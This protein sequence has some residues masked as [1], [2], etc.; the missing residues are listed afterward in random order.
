MRSSCVRWACQYG[1]DHRTWAGL[2]SVDEGRWDGNKKVTISQLLLTYSLVHCQLVATQVVLQKKTEDH[3]VSLHSCPFLD[4]I[5]WEEVFGEDRHIPFHS[6][7]PTMNVWWWRNVSFVLG[8]F[9]LS[10]SLSSR[11]GETNLN[12]PLGLCEHSTL[13]CGT[14]QSRSADLSSL[15]LHD[16]FCSRTPSRPHLG[17]N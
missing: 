1:H 6:S 13:E 7:L 15:S 10:F 17:I 9:F 3:I 11:H 12:C 14:H 16:E 4:K 2:P 8:S 5:F